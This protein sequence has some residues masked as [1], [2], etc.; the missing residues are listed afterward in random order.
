LF[1]PIRTTNRA[2]APFPFLFSLGKEFTVDKKAIEKSELIGGLL[3]VV[4]DA[5]QP[6]EIPD[7]ESTYMDKVIN[8]LEFHKTYYYLTDVD[9]KVC[10]YREDFFRDHTLEEVT[11]IIM[12]AD[13]LQLPGLVDDGCRHVAGLM[14]GKSPAQIRTMFKMTN[15]WDPEAY[16]EAKK[17]FFWARPD[18]E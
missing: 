15:D 12:L 9:A 2:P 6:L 11:D 8:W 14:R 18:E 13:T 10:Q 4:E 7:V 1:P 5:S 16:A 17:I 3:A